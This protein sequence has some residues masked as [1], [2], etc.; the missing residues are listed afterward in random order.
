[1]F[2]SLHALLVRF[3]RVSCYCCSYV[4]VYLN[5]ALI[6]QSYH[7]EAENFWCY[8]FDIMVFGTIFGLWG[9]NNIPTK[10]LLGGFSVHNR[11]YSYRVIVFPIMIVCILKSFNINFGKKTLNIVSKYLIIYMVDVY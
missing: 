9:Y 1:M 8:H 2:Y 5:A 4:F 11:P 10:W 3:Y 6:C 7:T